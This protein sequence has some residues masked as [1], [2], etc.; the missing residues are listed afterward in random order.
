MAIPRPAQWD[1]PTTAASSDLEFPRTKNCGLGTRFAYAGTCLGRRLF[2]RRRLLCWLLDA[3]RLLNR[4]A[5]EEAGRV[6][7]HDFHGIAKG[8]TAESL[9]SIL[10]AGGRVLDL[11]CGTGR[12]TREA[13]V[14]S[15]SVVG[16][17]HDASA[18]A[19]ARLESSAHTNISYFEGDASET[20]GMLFDVA[21]L[22]HVLEHVEDPGVLLTSLHSMTPRLIIEVP[23]FA[24]NP[25][26]VAR[27]WLHRPFDSDADHVREYTLETLH[28]Q[29]TS[30]AWSVD[31]IEQAGGSLVAIASGR[32]E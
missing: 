4:L 25:L 17:D 7:G 31:G 13:A 5:F 14:V 16:V 2:G 24:A 19:Q 23:D 18:I 10:P 32:V 29:L 9:W 3:A 21:L 12:W 8:M 22:I 30:S 11:G 26:N 15:A 6:F 1:G 20:A 27:L 28:A